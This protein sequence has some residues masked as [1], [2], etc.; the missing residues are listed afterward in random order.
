MTYVYIFSKKISTE[1]CA[2]SSLCANIVINVMCNDN[3]LTIVDTSQ[4]L[5][6]D[7]TKFL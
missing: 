7:R 4:L 1:R 5:L 6:F 2:E 3:G